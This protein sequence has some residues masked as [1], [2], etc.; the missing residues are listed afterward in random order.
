MIDDKY[1]GKVVLVN[2]PN[3]SRPRYRWIVKKRDDG[4]YIARTPKIGILIRDLN[5]KLEKDYNAEHILPKNFSF[6][7]SVSEGRKS[8]KKIK[9]NKSKKNKTRKK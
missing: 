8:K 5:K 1:I 3:N 9:K 7:K 4:R 6:W 2:L